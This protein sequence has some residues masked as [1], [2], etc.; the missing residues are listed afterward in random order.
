MDLSQ[1]AKLGKLIAPALGAIIFTFCD[2]LHS[3]LSFICFD[4][5]L[6]IPRLVPR[7]PV[8]LKLLLPTMIS[9]TS[10]ATRTSTTFLFFFF[11]FSLALLSSSQCRGFDGIQSDVASPTTDNGQVVHSSMKERQVG[12]T[13]NQGRSLKMTKNDS[14]SGKGGGKGKGGKK[15][16]KKEG[17]KEIAPVNRGERADIFAQKGIP[18]LAVSGEPSDFQVLS[19]NATSVEVDGTASEQLA[20]GGLLL[21][22]SGSLCQSCSPLYRKIESITDGVGTSK[23]LT[24]TFATF[25]DIFGEASDEAI[26]DDFIEPAL[27]CSHSSVRRR[28]PEEEDN[29]VNEHHHQRNL[30]AFPSTCDAW[31]TKN[32]DGRCSYTNCFVGTDGN[33]D[34]CFACKTSCDNGCGA[35]GSA[36]NTDGNFLLFDFGEACCIHDHCYSSTFSKAVCDS[37]FYFDMAS[38][39]VG[40]DNVALLRLG[41]IGIAISF[42]GALGCYNLATIFYSAVLLGGGAAYQSAVANQ[43]AY[44]QEDVCIAKCP[45]TQESGGQGTTTLRIDLLKSSGQFPISYEMYRIPDRLFIDYEGT[46]IFDTG[47]LVSGSLSTTVSFSGTSTIVDVTIDAPNSGTAWDVFIGCAE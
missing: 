15:E 42:Y 10:L 28:M 44:E 33:P 19:C 20:V 3:P 32:S 34:D 1:F 13:S 2:P 8:G 43:I 11:F 22:S 9:V 37:E 46:R 17:E 29:L 47:S 26:A 25:G 16:G 23:L 21:Y 41:R 18:A 4:T 5:L 27:G 45:S 38:E 36:L 35:S 7:A 40:L 6:L 14:N 30:L 24:T 39:C 31:Q 12:A